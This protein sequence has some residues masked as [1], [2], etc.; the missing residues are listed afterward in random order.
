ML[1]SLP[2]LKQLEGNL[3]R[4]KIEHFD[5]YDNLCHIASL[6]RQLHIQYSY[7][8]SLFMKEGG[9]AKQCPKFV[10]RSVLSLYQNEVKKSGKP[11]GYPPF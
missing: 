10:R 5:L 11:S 7:L 2:E 8:G 6:T 3:Q 4:M 1:A 9:D